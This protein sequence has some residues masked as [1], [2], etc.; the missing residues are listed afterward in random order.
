[1]TKRGVRGLAP[2]VRLLSILAG[3]LLPVAVVAA[4]PTGALRVTVYDGDFSVPL[5]HARVSVLGTTRAGSTGSDGT[6]LLPD[7]PAG[8]HTVSFSKDGYER[9]ILPDV[10]VTAGQVT[11]LRMDLTQQVVD[12]D[13]LVV[14]GVQF[15]GDSEIAALE[16]RAAAVNLQDTISTEL[17]AKAG[18]GDV[19][20][21]LKLVVGASVAE[22]KYA[23]VRGLSDR[24][25]GATLNGVRVPSA[26]PRR[27]AVQIDLFPTGTVEGVDV[28]KTFTPDLQ[29]DF[30]GGGVDI[31]TKAVPDGRVL[32][33]SITGE[34]HALAAGNDRFLTY[35]G[36]GVTATGFSGGER[37]RPAESNGPIPSVPNPSANPS[38]TAMAAAETIDRVVR[39]FDPV[40]GVM[41]QAPGGDFG[42]SVVGGDK[43]RLDNG[44]LIGFLGALTYSRKHDLYL[45]GTNATGSVSTVEDPVI[46]VGSKRTDSKGTEELLIGALSNLVF[47]P[48]DRHEYAF[49]L[50]AN[51]GAEDTARMQVL[52]TGATSI[53][54]NQGLQYTQRT[55]GSAQF[56]GSHKFSNPLPLGRRDAADLEFTWTA[57][58]N[59]TRQNEPDVRF[60]RNT[61]DL[62]SFA[63]GPPSNSNDYGRSRRIWRDISEDNHQASADVTWPFA[64]R[65]D[66]KGR[67]KAGLFYDESHRDYGQRSYYY[68]FVS[69]QL[70]S[71]SA[72]EIRRNKAVGRFQGD[73]PDDLWT[74]VFNDPDRIGLAPVR[75][76]PGQSPFRA[77]DNC[78]APNQLLWAIVPNGLDVDYDGEQT[79]DAAYAMAEVPLTARLKV[80]AGAR[81]EST[82]LSVDPRNPVLGH[83]EIIVVNESGSRGIN[84][85]P[86]TEGG[87]SID[88][89]MWLPAL[90]TVWELRDHMNLRVAWSRTIAR[91]T[92]RELAPVATEEFLNGDEFM[93]NP[94][95]TLSSIRNYDVRWE[96]FRG[97]GEVFA[98]SL[99][100]KELSRPIELISFVA[101]N[102][103]FVQPVN[104]DT[105]TVRGVELEARMG[106]GRVSEKLRPITLGMNYALIDSEVV[107]PAAEQASLSPFGLEEGTRRLQ[108]Q[109]SYLFNFFVDYDNDKTGTSVSLFYN[110]TGEV[111]L[112]GAAQGDSGTPNVFAAS[113]P[114]VAL[115]LRQKLWK[116]LSLS[117]KITNL[118]PESVRT[119]YR[120]PGRPEA[121][122]SER[123]TFRTFA[124]G[125]S[126]KW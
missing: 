58:Y 82:S 33:T 49:R 26:D 60:F 92:F 47:R 14:T 87:A 56:H 4:G 29:G 20:G 30:T 39:S 6:L 8:I 103:S 71:A 27:R 117:A 90:G 79:F 122:K 111:L 66:L 50:I 32:T 72:S 62:E 59:L 115:N 112:T 104:Y 118:L 2:R 89:T 21:A 106:L 64:L 114:V 25:T 5:S 54:Q 121:T 31:R 73:G 40:M 85:V 125:L 99:F 97:A 120:S 3:F 124:L 102:R 18:A 109:P 83:V 76:G 81:R 44:L 16:L 86:D 28:S 65:G 45:D 67:V 105:G 94:D 75:C 1:M 101:A 55:V 68:S 98:A 24:Y 17:I 88:E 43:W 48:S 41:Q 61:F 96:W 35:E 78:A 80:I 12:M 7:V 15:L 57:S 113:L 91:P 51:Q 108:G 42:A 63:A 22:G 37:D 119:F 52:G 93:G 116:G 13:E 53:E 84:Q 19:A 123:E 46:T 74:D 107:V 70:G 11:D 100:Y 77:S 126:M 95:L 9:R 36:G 23:T 110:L 10:A 69:N 34:R 38:P